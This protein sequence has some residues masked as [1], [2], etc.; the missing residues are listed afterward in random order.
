MFYDDGSQ[1]IFLKIIFIFFFFYKTKIKVPY[2]CCKDIKD[3]LIVINQ[4]IPDYNKPK[5]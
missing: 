1:N 4:R 3:Q 5:V 2:V